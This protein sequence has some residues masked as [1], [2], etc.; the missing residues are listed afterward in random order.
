M[1]QPDEP[2]GQEQ[3]GDDHDGAEDEHIGFADGA[4]LGEHLP[5]PREDDGACDGA[6]EARRA[7]EDGLRTGMKVVASK[8][9]CGSM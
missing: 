2:A 9:I 6:G 4:R 3:D 5:Q 7:A 1:D 8:A